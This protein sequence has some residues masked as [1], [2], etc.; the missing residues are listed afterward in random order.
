M[1]SWQLSQLQ[2]SPVTNARRRAREKR[3]KRSGAGEVESSGCSDAKE[4]EDHV[5]EG[6][7]G[8]EGDFVY[9]VVNSDGEE[10][11]YYSAPESPLGPED[12]GK[13]RKFSQHIIAI[14]CSHSSPEPQYTLLPYGTYVLC[15]AIIRKLKALF[16]SLIKN[17]VG[18]HLSEHGGTE[19]VRISEMFG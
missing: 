15:M 8:E 2:S 5:D 9:L 3:R 16:Y 4:G 18:S 14:V 19:R 12:D 7:C 1:L 13:S 6:D 17:T 10:E 11:C